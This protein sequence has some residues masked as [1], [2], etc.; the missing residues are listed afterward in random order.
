MARC[1]HGHHAVFLAFALA[2][3]EH[4]ALGVEVGQFETAKLGAPQ[5]RRVKQFEHGPVTHAQWIVHVGHGQKP[6]DFRGH[7]PQQGSDT[8][9]RE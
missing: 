4:A 6:F 9:E 8:G 2:D 1:P 5:A 3:V 7:L